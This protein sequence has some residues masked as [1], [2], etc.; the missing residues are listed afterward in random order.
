MEKAIPILWDGFFYGTTIKTINNGY[1]EFNFTIF[2]SV[3][4]SK[5]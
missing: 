1:A 4:A 5:K 2:A 3:Y